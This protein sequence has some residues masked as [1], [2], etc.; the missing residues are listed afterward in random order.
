MNSTIYT[1]AIG[2]TLSSQIYNGHHIAVGLVG[3]AIRRKAGY[4][5]QQLR[6]WDIL[7]KETFSIADVRVPAKR[8]KTRDPNKLQEIAEG[9][10][11]NGPDA[12][13]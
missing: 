6:N 9:I 2:I 10:L 12:P 5:Y 7:L 1:S 11:N 4:F 3:H 8:N 13:D